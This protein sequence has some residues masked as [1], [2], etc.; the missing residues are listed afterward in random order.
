MNIMRWIAGVATMLTLAVMGIAGTAYAENKDSDSKIS[1]LE[2]F[3]IARIMDFDRKVEIKKMPAT[4]LRSL[5]KR[6][7]LEKKL[8]S[9]AISKASK[10]WY[11]E[12]KT[13]GEIFPDNELTPRSI[14]MSQE[15]SSLDDANEQLARLQ[16]DEADRKET[17][18]FRER[19]NNRHVWNWG[20]SREVQK[21]DKKNKLVERA[22]KLVR[23]E[24]D[25]LIAAEKN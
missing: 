20:Y 23:D 10:I 15:F 19:Y 3:Y 25:K 24:L 6:I 7:A 11:D 16:H 1:E 17:D 4:E 14:M 21:K 22:G 13:K 8:F 2:P 9:T 12:E 18:T 5:V